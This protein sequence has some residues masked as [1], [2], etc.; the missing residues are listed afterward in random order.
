MTRLYIVKLAAK[1]HPKRTLHILATNGAHAI[2]IALDT[3]R[4][5]CQR[6]RASASPRQP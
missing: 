5:D 3:L 4:D 2:C 6:V 1:G